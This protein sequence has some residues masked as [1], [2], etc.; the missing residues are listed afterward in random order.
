MVVV[1][2]RCQKWKEH[3]EICKTAKFE[4]MDVEVNDKT[5]IVT[6]KISTGFV[7]KK[8]AGWQISIPNLLKF[9]NF[10][11]ALKWRT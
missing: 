9:S 4:A 8:P 6:L 3:N 10:L 5:A 1:Q 2:S 7:W 11:A